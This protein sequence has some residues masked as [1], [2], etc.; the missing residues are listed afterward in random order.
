MTVCPS[1]SVY[2]TEAAADIVGRG[3]QALQCVPEGLHCFVRTPAQPLRLPTLYAV[4][5]R[6]VCDGFSTPLPL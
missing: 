4:D 3:S 1:A 5:G 2:A 6:R